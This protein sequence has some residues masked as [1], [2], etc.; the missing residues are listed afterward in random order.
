GAPMAADQAPA[1]KPAVTGDPSGV[2]V[3]SAPDQLQ[4]RPAASPDQSQ[5]RPAASPDQPRVGVVSRE[6]ATSST[7]VQRTVSTTLLQ[8]PDERGNAFVAW[9]SGGVLLLVVCIS[10][11]T[12]LSILRPARRLR[13]AARRI[14]N[15]EA[16]VVVP[17]GGLRELDT[18]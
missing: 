4:A 12:A 13:V 10:A 3:M 1:S 17:R 14:A 6:S 8:T 2:G 11:F 5:V 16:G 7:S 15:G 18:L 9:V